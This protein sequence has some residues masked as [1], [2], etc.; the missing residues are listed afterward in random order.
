MIAAALTYLAIFNALPA[1]VRNVNET[2]EFMGAPSQVQIEHGN[3]YS[4]AVPTPEAVEAIAEYAVPVVDFGA[5]SGYW[6]M[7]LHQAGVDVVAYDDW[8]WGKPKLWFPV[9]DGGVEALSNHHDRAMLLVWPP[10][11]SSMAIN[12]LRAWDGDL[13][14]YVGEILRVNGT[15]AFFGALSREWHLERRVDLPNWRGKVDELYVL[16]RGDP[17]DE[18]MRKAYG[19][20]TGGA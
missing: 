16:R 7:L 2:C 5:G 11:E 10:A 12:A 13:L 8:S 9:K 4:W 17:D 19:R 14:F 20:C 3:R 6:S 18:W 15:P 1:E